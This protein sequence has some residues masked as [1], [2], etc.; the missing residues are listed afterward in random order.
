M[1]GIDEHFAWES[2]EFLRKGAKSIFLTNYT[3]D[4]VVEIFYHLTYMFYSV[5]LFSRRLL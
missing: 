1:R 3:V 5:F 4:V 2:K